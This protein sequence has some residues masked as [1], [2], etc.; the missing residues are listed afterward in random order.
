MSAHQVLAAAFARLL[1]QPVQIAGGHHVGRGE[2][3]HGELRVAQVRV[4]DGP[5]LHRPDRRSVQG[6]VRGRTNCRG[7]QVNGDMTGRSSRSL[8]QL[9]GGRRSLQPRGKQ[10]QTEGAGH[11][12]GDDRIEIRQR[13]PERGMKNVPLTRPLTA[14]AVPG[15]YTV[16]D[17]RGADAD[18]GALTVLRERFRAAPYQQDRYVLSIRPPD[19]RSI[20]RTCHA[21]ETTVHVPRLTHWDCPVVLWSCG[22]VRCRGRHQPPRQVAGR[23]VLDHL[24]A[25]S[26][27]NGTGVLL[28]Q[29]QDSLDI[30]R[31]RCLAIARHRTAHPPSKSAKARNPRWTGSDKRRTTAAQGSGEPSR[32]GLRT[33]A[34]SRMRRGVQRGDEGDDLTRQ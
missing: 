28:R 16:S 25:H 6:H 7:Q 2:V 30:D 18:L 32:P 9:L 31:L 33:G 8:V 15:T 14:N 13:V 24:V 34:M 29:G 12:A 10:T 23:E 1:E 4:H 26:T 20:T 27:A 3:L 17:H 22:P 19:L 21:A 11:G 5:A